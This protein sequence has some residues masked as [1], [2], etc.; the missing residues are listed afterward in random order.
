MQETRRGPAQGALCR[1]PLPHPQIE[2][3]S[4]E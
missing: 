2:A 3:S 1:T 4:G